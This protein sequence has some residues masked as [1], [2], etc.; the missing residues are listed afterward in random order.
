MIRLPTLTLRQVLIVLHDL[1][2]TVAAIVLTFFMRFEDQRLYERLVGLEIFLPIFL[3]GAAA[4]YFTI[5]L[6][7]NKWRV[8]S[9][10]DL[11][12]I[13]RAS[14]I[15]AVALLALDY[16]LLAPSFYG[17]FFFGKIT[18]LLYWLLQ[19]F[20]L[21]G[22]RVAYRYFHYARML[23]RVKIADATPTLILGRAMDAEVLLRS[24]ETGALKKIWPVGVLSPAVSD[25][26]QS[27]RGIPV[28]GGIDYLE[29]VVADLARRGNRVTRLVLAPSAL[30]PEARPEAILVR[31][32]RLRLSMRQIPSLD[33]G[34]A[35]VE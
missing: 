24:I 28:L 11:Y 19:M 8:T 13:F 35:T 12:N 10:P 31:A 33:A 3:I 29:S 22:S 1:L 16:V 17:T 5:G 6:H 4:V 21:G 14:T 15:L 34:G 27:I 26:G 7:H 2:A 23:Q 25:V 30:S 18:I 20:F 9:V 32:R